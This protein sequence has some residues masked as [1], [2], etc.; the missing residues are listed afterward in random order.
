MSLKPKEGLPATRWQSWQWHSCHLFL[1]AGSFPLDHH[2]INALPEVWNHPSFS[3]INIK[4]TGEED[5]IWRG[6]SFEECWQDVLYTSK[7]EALY[8]TPRT[9]RLN[10]S[11]SNHQFPFFSVIS[12]FN[13]LHGRDLSYKFYKLAIKI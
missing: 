11:F 9:W 1:Y 12:L 6:G 13:I 3:Y 4:I 8:N 10:Y 2:F 7:S 5:W